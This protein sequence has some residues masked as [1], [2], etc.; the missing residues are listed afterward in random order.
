MNGQ[1]S[2]VSHSIYNNKGAFALL[3]GSGVSSS[4]GIPTAGEI[5]LDLIGQIAVLEDANCEPSPEEWFFKRF[6]EKPG[7][8]S[9]LEPLTNTET[10]RQNL[11]RRYFEPNDAELE[12]GL[13]KPTLAHQIIARLVSK[14]YVR[15]IITTTLDRLVEN[16]LR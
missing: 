16:A 8:A 1:V 15:V 13:K 9:L 11:L 7:Y 6:G 12:E 2:S 3:L 4:A 10:E 14:G 5:A